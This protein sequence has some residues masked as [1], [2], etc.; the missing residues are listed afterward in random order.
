MKGPDM[1]AD[2]TMADDMV[3][4]ETVMEVT[5]MI[6]II[7]EMEKDMEVV[8]EMTVVTELTTIVRN[9]QQ[10]MVLVD[11]MSF[12]IDGRSDISQNTSVEETLTLCYKNV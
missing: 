8:I 11:T 6:H 3:S 10:N 1:I 12:S 5:D 4:M 7:T 2:V 9:L